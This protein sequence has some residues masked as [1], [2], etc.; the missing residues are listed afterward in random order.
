MRRPTGVLPRGE[1]RLQP[2]RLHGRAARPTPVRAIAGDR[3]RRG[4]DGDLVQERFELP[5]VVPGT[6]GHTDRERRA[7][8]R[9]GEDVELREVPPR[10]GVVVRPP[11]P[12]AEED[13]ARGVHRQGPFDRP[14]GSRGLRE[15]VLQGARDPVAA[16]V[17]LQ[18]VEV[19][20]AREAEV[21]TEEVLC[22]LVRAYFHLSFRRAV[23]LL[24]EVAPRDS[25]ASSAAFPV[26]DRG[27]LH[28]VLQ[29][30]AGEADL[31]ALPAVVLRPVPAVDTS[32]YLASALGQ[33]GIPSQAR[34]AGLTEEL[35]DL[36][37]NGYPA[38]DLS[39]VTDD[40]EFVCTPS[41][42]VE[43]EVLVGKKLEPSIAASPGSALPQT[44]RLTPMRMS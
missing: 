12:G 13:E 43:F 27:G 3:F 5:R 32:S 35:V 14:E 4:T 30:E 21:R 19:G 34:L 25:R 10:L 40:E 8:R 44:G 6:T 26:V 42:P 29:E 18:R 20:G 22:L 36:A 9:A 39:T 16:V 2:R 28:E 17:L 24:R 15:Q 23:G 41:R 38:L 37:L 1:V 11:R 31:L 7:V 33:G